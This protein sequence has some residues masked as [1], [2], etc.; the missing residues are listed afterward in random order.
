MRA[1]IPQTP[2]HPEEVHCPGLHPSSTHRGGS[3]GSH[4]KLVGW[5]LPGHLRAFQYQHFLQR[6]NKMPSGSWFPAVSPR[7]DLSS[8]GSSPSLHSQEAHPR[9]SGG[10]STGRPMGPRC[11]FH[12]NESLSL[13]ANLKNQQTIRRRKRKKY[14]KIRPQSLGSL[15]LMAE[16]ASTIGQ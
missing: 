15:L 13:W 7:L 11:P 8:Q 4:F 14:R 5:D 2:P 9:R 10:E 3:Q 12:T 1:W 6:R 16:K